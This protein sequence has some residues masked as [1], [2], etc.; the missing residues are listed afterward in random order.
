MQ[1]NRSGLHSQPSAVA[2]RI[3]LAILA[4]ASV[5]FA[6]CGF[7]T[8]LAAQ[9]EPG[10]VRDAQHGFSFVP[11]PGWEVSSMRPDPKV[12]LLYLGPTYRGG[13][14]NVNLV[15]EKDTGESFDEIA[16]Q[17]KEMYPRLFNAWK[18]AEEAPLE[19]DGKKA[20]YLSATHRMGTLTLRQA[21]FMVRGGNGKVYIVTFAAADD[22]FDRLSPAIA[23]SALSIRV[24]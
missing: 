5:G 15:V 16:Q 19:I 3:Y 10:R 4:L 18:L 12:R 2:R 22:A 1:I 8:E 6:T 9:Q 23:Q 17:I 7:L 24:E 21:Q 20:Y 13:R 11:P 14:A